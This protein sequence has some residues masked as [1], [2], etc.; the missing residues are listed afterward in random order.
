M[1]RE[2][3]RARAR[4]CD[5]MA[6]VASVHVFFTFGAKK[7]RG[8]SRGAYFWT[9][10]D[11]HSRSLQRC[12]GFRRTSLKERG[13]SAVASAGNRSLSTAASTIQIS[14]HRKSHAR[15]LPSSLRALRQGWRRHPQ[16]SSLHTSRLAPAPSA[17]RPLLQQRATIAAAVSCPPPLQNPTHPTMSMFLNLEYACRPADQFCPANSIHTHARRQASTH[18][19]K[20]T[21]GNTQIRHEWYICKTYAYSH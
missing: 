6:S 12:K 1:G 2:R 11:H 3:D 17:R 16:A 21:M 14:T 8:F 5:N 19:Q 10:Q 15:R 4:T 18:A 9:G 13:A 7:R 20:K